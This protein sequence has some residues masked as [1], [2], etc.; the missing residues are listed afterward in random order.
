MS[1]SRPASNIRRSN[2]ADS[3][4]AA[5]VAPVATAGRPKLMKRLAS[6]ALGIVREVRQPA[7]YALPHFYRGRDF[8]PRPDNRAA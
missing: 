4:P 1:E 6:A 2:Q 7:D 3:L 8:K 5:P